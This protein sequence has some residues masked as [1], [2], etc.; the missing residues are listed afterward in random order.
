M[1]SKPIV[2]QRL[3]SLNIGNST[4]YCKQVLT[5]VV[6]TKVGRK[7]FT[8]SPPESVSYFETKYHLDSWSEVTDYTPDSC[9]YETEQEWDDH[10]EKLALSEQISR[11]FRNGRNDL[12]LSTLRQVAALIA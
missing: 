10:K 5:P 8:C 11:Y 2:G 7:Y 1:K 9:L 12:S 3:F 6:V 4:R